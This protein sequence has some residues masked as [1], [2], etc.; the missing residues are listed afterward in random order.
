MENFAL[1]RPKTIYR[2]AKV[3]SALRLY[4][5]CFMRN[6]WESKEQKIVEIVLF[7]MY[8]HLKKEISLVD[9]E[10]SFKMEIASNY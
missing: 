6:H 8:R 5:R 9:L 4:M 7:F 2:F 10:A 3:E 1:Y